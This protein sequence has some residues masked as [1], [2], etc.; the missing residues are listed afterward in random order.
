MSAFSCRA[1]GYLSVLRQLLSA[2]PAGFRATH[3]SWLSQQDVKFTPYPRYELLRI[4]CGTRATIASAV[5][6]PP[7]QLS[8]VS[9]RPGSLRTELHA[10]SVCFTCPAA[11]E[12]VRKTGLLSAKRRDGAVGDIRAVLARQR[13]TGISTA[14]QGW[15]KRNYED[16]AL[17]VALV[18]AHTQEG[19]KGFDT[20]QAT[21]A[22]QVAAPQVTPWGL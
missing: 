4:S 20:S 15:R 9:A 5:A 17:R 14:V 7:P 11:I 19:S 2:H 22:A 10:T 13:H 1:D 6:P 8:V 12:E 18:Q 16:Q 21:T 3:L